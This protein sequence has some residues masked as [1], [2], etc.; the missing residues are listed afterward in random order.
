MKTASNNTP[1]GWVKLFY[2][3]KDWEWYGDPNMVALFVHLLLSANFKTTR[4]RGREIPRGSFVT[5]RAQLS[6]ATGLSEQ[7]VRTCLKRLI[8][9]NEITVQSTKEFTIVTICKFDEYQ[10]AVGDS[11]QLDNQEANQR[12]T[13]DP[14]SINQPL[15]TSKE[16]KKERIYIVES[17][18]ACA[19]DEFLINFFSESRSQILAA[20]CM[21]MNADLET[22][23]RIAKEVVDEWEVTSQKAHRELSD[24]Q[25]HLVSQMRIKLSAER[26]EAERQQPRKP[27]PHTRRA[28]TA[29]EKAPRNVSARWNGFETPTE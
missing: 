7:S 20:L 27:Q 6:S 4:W 24:A 19:R 13:N 25:R 1:T 14:P 21:N 10:D 16:Y 23:K 11:N 5:S 17:P 9:T 15:T 8:S 22:L 12:L 18:H 3:F 26:R 29:Q 2:R 28:K